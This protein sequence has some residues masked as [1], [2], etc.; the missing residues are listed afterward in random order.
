VA[1]IAWGR[2]G[3]SVAGW[4]NAIKARGQA[5]GSL[6]FAGFVSYGW[7]GNQMHETD[8]NRLAFEDA[9]SALALP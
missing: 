9:Y 1:G 6:G 8:A 2:A 3:V 4:Q 7:S 5:A